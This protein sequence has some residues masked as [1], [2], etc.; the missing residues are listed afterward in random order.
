LIINA[1]VD[2]GPFNEVF[3]VTLAGQGKDKKAIE[4]K[5]SGKVLEG[6]S[7]KSD[8]DLAKSQQVTTAKPVTP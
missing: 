4:L 1:P 2:A 5:L 6:L 8:K 3:T 7:P